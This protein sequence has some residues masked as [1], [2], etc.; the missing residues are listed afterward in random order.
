M[1][2]E[3]WLWQIYRDVIDKTSQLQ[4]LVSQEEKNCKQVRKELIYPSGLLINHTRD[5]S[6]SLKGS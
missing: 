6:T 4:S 3:P 2:Q 1:Q 5:F